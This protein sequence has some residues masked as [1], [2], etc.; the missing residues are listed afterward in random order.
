MTGVSLMQK[1]VCINYRPESRTEAGTVVKLG[2]NLIG[3]VGNIIEAGDLGAVD[4]TGFYRLSK[5]SATTFAQGAP[6]YVSSGKAVAS[7]GDLFGY[8]V[9]EAKTGENS[10]DAMLVCFAPAIEAA[11]NAS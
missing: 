9:A 2:D 3:V 1:G 7:G 10:V 11:K 5:D 6:V 8:A 4:L